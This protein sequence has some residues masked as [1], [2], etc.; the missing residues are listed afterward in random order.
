MKTS[1]LF[2]GRRL[3]TSTAR[4]LAGRHAELG[5]NHGRRSGQRELRN[6]VL[7]HRDSIGSIADAQKALNLSAADGDHPVH[8]GCDQPGEHPAMR[9]STEIGSRVLGHHMRDT[10]LPGDPVADNGGVN[11]L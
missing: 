2:S 6:G 1:M 5:A 11:A 3:A 4:K 8:V 7:D 9:R 10:D